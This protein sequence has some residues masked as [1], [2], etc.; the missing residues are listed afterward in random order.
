MRCAEMVSRQAAR[1]MQEGTK[2]LSSV[3]PNQ[4]PGYPR[5]SAK[6]SKSSTRVS[7]SRPAVPFTKE[8]RERPRHHVIAF[9]HASFRDR[10]SGFPP[11][12]AGVRLP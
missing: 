1:G 2:R 10:S 4:R 6:S 8:T 5:G 9:C 7:V 3:V 12:S 11:Q